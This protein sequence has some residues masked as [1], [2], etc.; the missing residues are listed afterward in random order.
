MVITVL[1]NSTK[2]V[3][4]LYFQIK[5]LFKFRLFHVFIAQRNLL[6]GRISYIIQLLLVR[7]L[8]EGRNV[9][10]L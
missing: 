8:F 4:V 5:F 1:K 9:G 10:N 7:L 6:S 3:R 2:I